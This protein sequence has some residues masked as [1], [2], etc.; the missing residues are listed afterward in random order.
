MKRN[1]LARVLS[2]LF[3]AGTALFLVIVIALHVLSPEFSP[4]SH[5]ISE[6]AL[7]RFVWPLLRRVQ[8]DSGSRAVLETV[9]RRDRAERQRRAMEFVRGAIARLTGG[10]VTQLD[11]EG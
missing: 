10:P 1:S 4:I 5:F 7:G 2:I 9:A 8:C 11:I 6:Y 3:I